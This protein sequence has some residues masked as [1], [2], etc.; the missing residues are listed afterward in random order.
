MDYAQAKR[1]DDCPLCGGDIDALGLGAAMIWW[2]MLG[3]I[4]AAHH[5]WANFPANGAS[6]EV[7]VQYVDLYVGLVRYR[8]KKF[9]RRTN[10]VKLV[11]FLQ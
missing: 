3:A 7:Y 11:L 6:R 5:G 2:A 10:G 8:R 4:S 1:W 9:L